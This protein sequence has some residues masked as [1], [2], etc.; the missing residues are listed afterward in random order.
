M[1][2][3]STAAVLVLVTVCLALASCSSGGDTYTIHARFARAVALYDQSAVLLM[4]VRVGEVTSIDIDGDGI[5]VTMEIAD[6][7]PLS[8][9]VTAAI[10]PS[11]LI[12]ER[13]VA[14]G[15]PWQPG[16]GKLADGDT[17]P[18]DRTIIP[19][20]PDEALES[21][22]NL[23]QSLDPD[24]V[25][26][27]L[28]SG[29]Q[30]LDGN[31]II[32]NRTLVELSQLLPYLAE[33]DDELLALAGDVNVLADAVRSRDQQIGKLLDDFATVT[34]AVAEE[35]ESLKRFF[36]AIAS[37]S[38]QGK[39]LLTAYE[40][41]LPDDLDTLAT[42]AFTVQVNSEAVS[43]ALQSINGFKDGVFDAYD[44]VN[45]SVR[46]RVN[47]QQSGLD[48]L[49]AAIDLLTGGTLP[50]IELAQPACSG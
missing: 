8:E 9:K 36:N 1:I 7:V 35:R 32:I 40:V 48:P 11:S 37:L 38:A 13:N 43:R 14:L 24:S 44:P 39:A 4:G 18:L 3:R 45:K 28:D 19:V 34:D 17:I 30:A 42:V 6:D 41:T 26:A 12:G 20:E 10:V 2:R 27:L 47:V 33:Q 21:V 50:C 29:S 46:A 25:A 31:G 49:L 22:T 15:P 16:A 5:A 23:L